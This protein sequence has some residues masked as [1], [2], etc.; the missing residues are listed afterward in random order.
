ME[1]IIWH[2]GLG[3]SNLTIVAIAV[4]CALVVVV[5]CL[6]GCIIQLRGRERA[7]LVTTKLNELSEIVSVAKFA[8]S[9][10]ED[11]MLHRY[12]YIH[13][14]TIDKLATAKRIFISLEQKLSVVNSAINA[15]STRELNYLLDERI[16]LNS[17]P[18]D[19]IVF[20]PNCLDL[21]TSLNLEEA[22]LF[23]RDIFDSIK[24]DLEYI[25]SSASK[26]RY[27]GPKYWAYANTVDS[28]Y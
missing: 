7:E 3:S 2:F 17:S 15:L 5:I 11:R 24:G 13:N 27:Y 16:Q 18:F 4:T 25:E 10:N 9:E 12:Y 8:V 23:L 6:L 20:A 22:I 26:K 1:S 21:P 28:S 14:R 19:V